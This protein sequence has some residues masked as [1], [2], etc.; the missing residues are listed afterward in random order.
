MRNLE[1]RKCVKE[2]VDRNWLGLLTMLLTLFVCMPQ[3]SWASANDLRELNKEIREQ[4]ESLAE[5]VAV[6]DRL[7]RRTVHFTTRETNWVP[8]GRTREF[9]KTTTAERWR[10][11]IKSGSFGTITYDLDL[12]KASFTRPNSE[13]RYS[14]YLSAR[15]ARRQ[16]ERELAGLK[17]LRNARERALSQPE[18]TDEET[19]STHQVSQPSEIVV[20]VKTPDYIE[21]PQNEVTE[22]NLSAPVMSYLKALDEFLAEKIRTF[23]R[24]QLRGWHRDLVEATPYLVNTADEVESDEE[25][26]DRVN[27]R[28]KGLEK[29]RTRVAKE[30]KEAGLASRAISELEED[31]VRALRET[32]DL[33]REFQ[34]AGEKK[35]PLKGRGSTT[36][37]TLEDVKL[38]PVLDR[39]PYYSFQL[40]RTKLEAHSLKVNAI[41]SLIDSIRNDGATEE[42]PST[43]DIPREVGLNANWDS[44]EGYPGV[45]DK[46][47]SLYSSELPGHC[48]PARNPA[49]GSFSSLLSIL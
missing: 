14:E 45:K 43:G 32:P 4:K 42:S 27:S 49:P 22:R 7:G 3:S 13:E 12:R 30:I 28:E 25:I 41:E 39:Y 21:K 35:L 11:L 17:Q 33:I 1:F 47:L 24:L 44:R 16:A 26:A 36:V 10:R 29:L 31:L 19:K 34:E 37:A 2:K 40:A 20:V 8:G 15:T 23:D 46:N 5:L 9:H 48:D 38:V 6:E 18:R